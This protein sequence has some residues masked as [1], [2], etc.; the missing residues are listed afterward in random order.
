MSRYL[1]QLFV[2]SYGFL[3]FAKKMNKNIC[4]NISKILKQEI[5]PEIY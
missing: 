5:Q 4:K 2:K 1:D 3:P